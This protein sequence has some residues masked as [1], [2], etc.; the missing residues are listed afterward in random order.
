MW[1]RRLKIKISKSLTFERESESTAEVRSKHPTGGQSLQVLQNTFITKCAACSWS[2][3]RHVT[4]SLSWLLVRSATRPTEWGSSL[5]MRKELTFSRVRLGCRKNSTLVFCV[6]PGQAL[7]VNVEWNVCLIRWIHFSCHLS[8]GG[9]LLA[10]PLLYSCCDSPVEWTEEFVLLCGLFVQEV[11]RSNSLLDPI[12]QVFSVTN[13]S[14]ELPGNKTHLRPKH[15]ERNM[16]WWVEST[17]W[18]SYYGRSWVW[19]ANRSWQ[20]ETVRIRH[21]VVFLRADGMRSLSVSS[22]EMKV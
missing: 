8:T 11:W 9:F 13:V 19:S 16:R 20:R 12:S 17:N 6:L 18:A 15:H 5:V 2:W 3:A 4:L 22:A 1:K 21:L 10:P 7:K 14:C